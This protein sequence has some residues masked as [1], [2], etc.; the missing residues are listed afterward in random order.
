MTPMVAMYLPPPRVFF[1]PLYVL[2]LLPLLPACARAWSC[3]AAGCFCGAAWALSAPLT[4][5]IIVVG[6]AGRWG[7]D[8][9]YAQ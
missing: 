4:P 6:N 8:A 1:T 3:A 5:S 2:A 9:D 7:W